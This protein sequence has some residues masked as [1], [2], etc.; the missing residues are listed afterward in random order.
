MRIRSIFQFA[1]FLT[2]AAAGPAF[3]GPIV[4]AE[5]GPLPGGVEIQANDEASGA[6]YVAQ[7]GDYLPLFTAPLPAEGESFTIWARG[8]GHGICLKSKSAEGKQREPQVALQLADRRVDLALLRH[9]PPGRTRRGHRP[10]PPA[11]RRTRRRPRRGRPLRRSRLPS[12]RCHRSEDRAEASQAQARG[13]S[14]HRRDGCSP[15]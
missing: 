6:S 14:R 5:S 2:F 12:T 4:E 11:Q 10:H 13:R 9:L 1:T 7:P 15:G 8:R 3:A